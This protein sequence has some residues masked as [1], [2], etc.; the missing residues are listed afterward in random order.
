MGQVSVTINNRTYR[1]ACDAGEEDRLVELVAYLKAKV[2]KLTAEVGHVGDERLMFMA[3]LQIADELL[4]ARSGVT[5][6]VP[7]AGAP[8][9][10]VESEPVRRL[11]TLAVKLAA[12]AGSDVFADTA[13]RPVADVPAS[14]SRRRDVA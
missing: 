12:S 8:E 7:V 1:L 14:K 13:D 2:E 5:A 9:E 4:D 6:S 11:Q 3:A 10:L